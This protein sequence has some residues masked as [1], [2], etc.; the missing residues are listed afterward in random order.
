MGSGWLSNPRT[1]L[2]QHST[3]SFARA[4]EPSGIPSKITNASFPPPKRCQPRNGMQ[5]RK[6]NAMERFLPQQG[7]MFQ[8]PVTIL[9]FRKSQASHL[10]WVSKTEPLIHFKGILLPAQLCCPMGYRRKG[11]HG[12]DYS[13]QCTPVP[14]ALEASGVWSI[15]SEADFP[16]CKIGTIMPTRGE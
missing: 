11:L 6:T 1:H 2:A 16:G 14:R 7:S 13:G 10:Q 15:L 5:E 12:E 8:A 3:Q 4:E 9:C